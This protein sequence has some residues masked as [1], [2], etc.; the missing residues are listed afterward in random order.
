MILCAGRGT[1]LRPLTDEL[2]KPMVPVGD[3]PALAHIVEGLATACS[4]IVVNVHHRPDDVRS[5]AEP[6]GLSV[7]WEPELLGT[8]GGVAAAASLLGPG[9]VLLWNG[10]IQSDLDPTLLLAASP[11]AAAVLAV[12]PRP[13]G[14]GNVGVDPAGRIVRLRRESV[15]PETTGGDFLGIHRLGPSLRATL[16]ALG[17][18]VTDV[19]L[20]ALRRGTL[21]AAHLTDA[22]FIDIGT[23]PAYLEA[24]A[25]W[26]AARG[27]PSFAAPDAHV[28]A[29]ID[30]SVIGASARIS[31]PALRSVVWPNA[32]VLAP[33]TDAV[34]TPLSTPS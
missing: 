12:R 30:G 6:R 14:E 21:L 3:R 23:I 2:A 29:P 33:V 16:P 10:D 17:C 26:L 24:N 22:A 7:S 4:R 28:T 15:A 19:Y 31:A 34:I 8:A 9:S 1:R 13:A 20:P 11:T 18:L 5:W 27:A 25:R 32:R